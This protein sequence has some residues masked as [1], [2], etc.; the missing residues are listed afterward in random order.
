MTMTLAHRFVLSALLLSFASAQAHAQAS[1]P[2]AQPVAQPATPP[3]VQPAVQPATP[4]P[5][6]APQPSAAQTTDAPPG[7]FALDVRIAMP[8]FNTGS[9]LADPLSLRTSQ[10]PGRGWGLEFGATVYPVRRK[11]FAL[12]LGASLVRTSGSKAPDPEDATAATDPTIE[13]RFT[14]LVP[15]VSLNFGSSRG[16]SYI[17]GG[18]AFMRRATGDV[19]AD[20]PDG[21]RL[22]GIHYGGGARW[23]M[24]RHVAFSFDLRF[25]RI[26]E[27]AAEAS[28]T[29][30][31][32]AV[33]FQ[34]KSRLFL[35]SVGLSFK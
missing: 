32:A 25:Y 3:P 17:G 4:A 7:P 11:R 16:W 14:A 26:P 10:L 5:A 34:P 30:D 20:V 18:Y 6:A 35:A 33:P 1:Q 31:I 13:T 22:M 27:Q 23:Y 29:A 15:Q 28:T 2:A 9:A 8:S 12:G 21:P 19:E 24:A